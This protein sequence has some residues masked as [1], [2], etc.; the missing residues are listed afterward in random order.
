M[1]R[2]TLIK[3]R[4]RN[5]AVDAANAMA[6]KQVEP[7]KKLRAAKAS[8]PVLAADGYFELNIDKMFNDYMATNVK[9]WAHDRAKTIGASEIFSCIRQLFFAKRGKEFGYEPD[10]D[11]EES[12]G[13][14][15][16]GNIIENHFVVPGLTTQLPK[17]VSLEYA[18]DAQ[19]TL[20]EKRNSATPDGLFHGLPKAPLRIIAGKKVVEL[21]DFDADCLGLEIKSIDPRAN[22]ME[23]RIKHRGQSQVGLGLI[24][25][26]T[27]WKP[28]HWLIL[29]IDA[30]FL[31][32]I[33]PFLIEWDPDV[34]ETAKL[35]APAIWEHD[36][37]MEFVG[38]GK[39]T[40]DCNHC[41][42][43]RA[44]GQAVLTEWQGTEEKQS[45]APED[46][47]AVRPLAEEY[48]AKKAAAEAAELEF[49]QVKQALKDQMQSIGKRK[50]KADEWSV[51]WSARDGNETVDYKALIEHHKID[52][53]P[54]KR[55]GAAVDTMRVTPRSKT[56][57]AD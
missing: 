37:P 9:T 38:E 31:D 44:C 26:K 36:D 41:K 27:K 12:W 8:K 42:F 34:Y 10:E 4:P 49:D 24:R 33:T 7:L 43:K 30:S 55:R 51:A 13:A 5:P 39:M 40:G 21:P 57:P 53:E 32:N 3:P 16:R 19:I 47:E 56:A 23:E 14:T 20:V 48:L 22:L 17:G 54:F 50:V 29:Y 45:S 35:R 6:A 2:T 11:Y 18:G 52:P 46:I 1:A 25:E 28:T 15:E